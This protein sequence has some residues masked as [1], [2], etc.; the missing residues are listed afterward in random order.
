MLSDAPFVAVL[1]ASDMERAKA[2]Y[3][4]KLGM[5]VVEESPGGVVFESGSGSQFLV[6]PYGPTK[7]EHTV[8]GFRVKDAVAEINALKAKGVV[9]EEYDLPGLKMVDG[10]ANL[11][12]GTGGWFKDT[13]GN[14][15]GIAEM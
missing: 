4:N 9:F 11:G 7:A 5:K 14:I 6:Y 3:S 2:F 12:G 13:E 1:P 8:A 15:L 10:I